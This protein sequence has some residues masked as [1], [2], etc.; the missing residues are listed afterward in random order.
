[1]FEN[2]VFRYRSFNEENK[3]LDAFDKDRLYV[4]KYRSQRKR[5][6]FRQPCR[7]KKLAHKAKQIHIR[8]IFI[9]LFPKG[10]SFFFF[11]KQEAWKI[12]KIKKVNFYG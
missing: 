7:T 5:L 10:D 3:N 12:K 4:L 6:V 1:M 2:C 11:K 9:Q 8:M